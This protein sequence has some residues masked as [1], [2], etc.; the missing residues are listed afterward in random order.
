MTGADELD[1][2]LRTSLRGPLAFEVTIENAR[3][4]SLEVT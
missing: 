2:R 4:Y 3:L 1:R